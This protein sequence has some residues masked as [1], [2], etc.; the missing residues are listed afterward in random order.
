MGRLLTTLLTFAIPYVATSRY[1]T[2]A[3]SSPAVD[4][5]KS[6]VDYSNAAREISKRQIGPEDETKLVSAIMSILDAIKKLLNASK[7]ELRYQDGAA[8]PDTAKHTG[9]E[10]VSKL[11]ARLIA[12]I[13]SMYG[14]LTPEL[15]TTIVRKSPLEFVPLL[16]ELH[17][18][19]RFVTAN[20]QDYGHGVLTQKIGE[21]LVVY[22]S[23]EA[24]NRIA[25]PI[26]LEMLH[27]GVDSVYK[28]SR[29]ITALCKADR[30]QDPETI[31]NTTVKDMKRNLAD[32]LRIPIVASEVLSKVP[33]DQ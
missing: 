15:I 25:K 17:M 29:I 24:I 23:Y 30:E 6:I 3:G 4:I 21:M 10:S 28:I 5:N 11:M 9:S 32:D 13:H 33:E 8:F 27:R 26:I 20:T 12:A 31:V 22:I 7:I 19:S 2:V 16:K 18:F 14:I 1:A